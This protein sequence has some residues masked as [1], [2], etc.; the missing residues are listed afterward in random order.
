[1]EISS[2]GGRPCLKMEGTVSFT[3][4]DNL[5][6]DTKVILLANNQDFISYYQFS[7]S[8]VSTQTNPL[9]AASFESFSINQ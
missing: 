3:G 6:L 5:S 9:F 1:V 7:N 8:S 2:W 4:E